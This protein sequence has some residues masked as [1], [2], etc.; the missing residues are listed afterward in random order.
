MKL[1]SL[2]GPRS[3]QRYVEPRFKT[4]TFLKRIIFLKAGTCKTCR[5]TIVMHVTVIWYS[6]RYVMW[7]DSFP[8]SKHSPGGKV[9][10]VTQNII[11]RPIRWFSYKIY[12]VYFI[13]P[14]YDNSLALALQSTTKGKV[15]FI[16]LP[17]K[18]L[19]T[20]ASLPT[21]TITGTSDTVCLT[22]G[23]KLMC[24]HTGVCLSAFS[25]WRRRCSYCVPHIAVCFTRL[26]HFLCGQST[27]LQQAIS[28]GVKHC[29]ISFAYY[30]GIK[31]YKKLN[32]TFCFKL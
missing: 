23:W 21:S 17:S 11:Q 3:H 12:A 15:K 29:Y 32:Y 18:E 27:F 20:I 26:H 16:C 7:Q 22:T 14:P 2:I 5:A 31:E 13:K 6:L 1:N 10:C 9:N 8:L 25:C 19:Y 4:C 30:F 28:Q 24:F